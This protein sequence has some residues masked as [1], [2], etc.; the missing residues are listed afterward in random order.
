MLNNYD[1]YL[2]KKQRQIFVKPKTYNIKN[3]QM[4]KNGRILT[5]N[6]PGVPK[7]IAA[8][9]YMSFVHKSI[10]NDSWDTQ[11]NRKPL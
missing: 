7:W 5:E 10:G 3:Y 8:T 11:Y 1:G 6:F 2:R 9:D 4:L